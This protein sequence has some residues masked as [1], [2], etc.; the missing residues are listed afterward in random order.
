MLKFLMFKS[1][2]L[3]ESQKFGKFP[4]IQSSFWIWGHNGSNHNGS[5]F[6]E[7]NGVRWS[8]GNVQGSWKLK[9]DGTELFTRFNNIDHTLKY[10]VSS[11]KA[12]LITPVRNPPSVMWVAGPV[13]PDPRTPHVLPHPL[14][15]GDKVVAYGRYADG[16]PKFSVNIVKEPDLKCLNLHVDFRPPHNVSETVFKFLSINYY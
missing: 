1:N 4:D 9:K 10:D 11:Q 12:I 8:N 6:F 3:G 5:L 13:P 14:S 2:V 16:N 15:C 7:N